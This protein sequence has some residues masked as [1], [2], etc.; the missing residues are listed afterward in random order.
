MMRAT[1][2]KEVNYSL[3][4]L[5]EDIDTG[6]IGLPDIQR[7]FV[8]ERARVRDLFDSMYNGFPIGYLLFWANGAAPGARQIGITRHQSA[9]RLL[10]VDGQQRLTSLYGVMKGV[11]VVDDDYQESLI[12]IAFRPRDASFSVA[13]ATTNR[14]PEYISNIS[15]LWVGELPRN[16]FVRAFIQK[17]RES[18][19]VSDDEEDRLVE[20]IDRLYDLQSYPFTALELSQNVDEEQV[21]DVFVRINSQAVQLK[22]ADFILTLMSVFWDEGRKQLEE[23]CRSARTPTAGQ[24]SAYNH[25]IQP[26]PD[27]L[28]RVA[29]GLGFRRG[30]L[31]FVYS[32]LRG[33]DLETEQ[34][35]D[36]LREQQFAR[37]ED[38]Q[39]K[40]LDL[41]NWHQYLQGLV[42][43]GYRHGRMI[44]SEMNIIYCYA[45]FLIGKYSF[46]VEPH[47]LRETIARWF[48]MTAITSRYSSSPE[49]TI[50]SDL[51]ELRSIETAEQFVALL[52]GIVDNT[53]TNDFWEITLPNELG[54]SAA[55]SPSVY[56]YYAALNLLDA[57]VLFSKMRVRDLFD[58]SITP[59]RSPLERH[60][61]FPKGHLSE[62]GIKTNRDQNQIG[63]FAL[64]EWPDNST[65]SDQPPTEYFPNFFDRLSEAEKEK[66]T[67]WHA[68]PDGWENMQYADFLEVRR[69]MLARVVREGFN[70]LRHGEPETED[71]RSPNLF[72][73][74]AADLIAMGETSNIEFKSSARVD[75]TG[76][77][78]DFLEDAIVKTIAG[79]LNA[80]GGT[81]LIGVNDEGDVLGLD[82]DFKTLR[83]ANPDGYELWLHDLFSAW[84]GIPA[85][86]YVSVNFDDVSDC[87][88]CRIGVRPSSHPVYANKPK[89]PES[90]TFYVRTG[91]STRKLTT[92]EAVTYIKGRWE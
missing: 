41:N 11:P 40:T 92:D 66:A 39:S 29:I 5:I 53:L 68:L 8:W 71:E 51:A 49:S 65:I 17:L 13:D 19:E 70:R 62:I 77:R 47:L 1:Q 20:E 63:N 85:L 80:D 34:Y 4:K 82:R 36:E 37:L 14:D 81:L 56:A 61:L 45:L 67:F 90:D 23:F 25:F 74:S 75:M 69:G 28:L 76:D 27:Q 84:L 22:Q 50:E 32:V 73:L 33:K 46:R 57:N 6:E 59:P 86:L 16:R 2:F 48:F 87:K 58:P 9:P 3:S 26:A 42:R 44:T 21:A 91:N 72:D 38:A 35:S 54:S 89:N 79:F 55:R 18:R 24:S 83:K 30:V 52:T 31:R 10:I 43:A 64:L 7:P 12:K 15:D 88:I 60:H 78:K